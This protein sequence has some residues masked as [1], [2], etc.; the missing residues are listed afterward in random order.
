LSGVD[1]DFVPIVVDELNC[2]V[3]L[4]SGVKE[5]VAW[6]VVVGCSPSYVSFD[7]VRKVV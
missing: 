4:G 2:V 1:S 6:S 5:V 7:V 3:I